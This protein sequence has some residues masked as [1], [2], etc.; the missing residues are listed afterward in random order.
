MKRLLS[1][2]FLLALAHAQVVTPFNIRYQTTTNGNIV[3]IGNTLMCM[4]VAFSLTQCSTT[5]MNDPTQNNTALTSD[6]QLDSSR[7]MIFINADP[8]N[9]SWPSGRGGSTAA[10]LSLPSGAQVL[11]AGLY[12]GAR[13]N[14]SASGRNQIYIKGPGQSSYQSLSGT[15]IGT[16]TDWGT[17]TT[18]PYTAFADVTSLVQNRG[19]GQYWVGGILA[20]TGNDGLGFYAG[21]A[22]V[23]VYRL[24][25]EPLR[26]LVVYDGL[27]SVSSGNPVTVTPSGFL[28]PLT[29]PFTAYLGA[30]AFEGDGGITGDQVVLN[31][32]P[33][34]DAQNPVNNFF[35]SSVSQLGTRFTAKNPDYINQM[36]VDVDLVDVTGRIPNGAT[37]AT[38]QFTS[39]GDTYFPTVLA[40]A[41]QVFL[42]DLTTTFTKTG[43]DLNGGNLE[44]GD[45]LEYTI[46]FTNTGLDGATN[47]VVRDPIPP[48]TQYVPGS[49]QVLQNATGAPTGT[50]T[51]APGDDIA[52]YDS[53]GGRVVF[54]LG[55]G[56]NA[57][58]GGL[59]LPSQGATV[60]FRVRVLPSAAGQALTNTAQVT[61]NSQT[62]GTE[63]SQTASSSI[64]VSVQPAADLK[65]TKTGPASA[66][67]GGPISYTVTVENLGP[68]PVTGASFTD[69]VPPEIT[70][71]AWSCTPSGGASC[72]A[73]SGT[74]NAI[75]LTLNLPVGGSVTIAISGTVSPSAAGQTL[76]NTASAFPP[77]GVTEVNPDDN[78]SSAST[79]VALG[80]TLLGSVYHDREPNGAKNGEDWSSGVTVY[81]KLVQGS[82]VVAVQ[83]VSPSAGTYAFSAVVPGTYTLVLDDNG[84]TSD[85][86]PTPP[87]GWHFINP[88]SGALSVTVNG[89]LSGLDFGLFHGTRLTGTVFYDDG[90]GGNTANNAVKEGAERGVAGVTVT[91]TDGT[92]TR[93]ALTDGNGNYL[94]WIPYGWGTVTLSHP[95]RPATGWNDGSTAHPVGSFSDANAP[96]SPGAVVNLGAAS[97]L[98]PVLVRHFGVVRTSLLRPPQSGQTTSPGVHTFAHTFRP[99]TLGTFTL[100][101]GSGAYAYQVRADRNCDGDFDDAGEGFS[102]FPLTLTVGSAWPREADGS[103]KA[104]ALEVRALVPPGEPAGRTDVALLQGSLAWAGSGVAEPLALTDLLTVIG[105]EVRLTKEVRNATQGGPFGGTAQAKPGEVLEYCITYRNLG[106]APV[107][108]LTLADPIPF[109][110]DLVLG[111]YGGKELRWTHGSTVQDLT[112]AQ[113]G[114]AGHVAGGVVYLLVGTVNPGESGGLCYR[115]Q[116][117]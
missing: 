93:T 2:A 57:S 32:S 30:V 44:V 61:Y 92:H 36:A 38:I 45:I 85:A 40:F 117:R 107:T 76:A 13:A 103:L 18:R 25:S 1:L 100:D 55:T 82:A 115:V 89:D 110:S 9:P 74:G 90:E 108:N 28:T 51:D 3:L 19:N 26:N 15:L 5:R 67:P 37:S 73:P 96:T 22:L 62:L 24:P 88:G 8:A 49:L 102:P 12:W 66:L 104:C 65:V 58:Q 53:T 50:F 16:I 72:S 99:G 63:F 6:N 14:P 10:T 31:G 35:N 69:N 79:A 77:A 41:T 86:T 112:A 23:V 109:F 116:V 91:A 54:R 27:A 68:S 80:Y 34:S 105:G 56:A 94:L 48:G 81:V 64:T 43:Q 20:S 83:A 42:P 98:P 97:S 11:W 21:W 78:S 47:V 95:T 7:R 33:V 17:D 4:S 70:G 111:A 39:S 75:S 84:N 114:D 87:P 46:S 29:G 113:D 59:I 52:E 71:V 60:K 106:T 101:L